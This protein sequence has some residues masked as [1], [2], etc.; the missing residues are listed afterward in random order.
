MNCLKTTQL[1]NTT[2]HLEKSKID[3]NSLKGDHKE[4]GKTIN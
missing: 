2:N 1:K 4:F 3:E